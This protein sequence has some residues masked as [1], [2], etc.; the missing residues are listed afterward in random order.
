MWCVLWSDFHQQTDRP[1]KHERKEPI[2]WSVWKSCVMPAVVTVIE[3][4]QDHDRKDKRGKVSELPNTR[5]RQ[6]SRKSTRA[7]ERERTSNRTHNCDYDRNRNRNRNCKP[8]H[9]V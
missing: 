2:L 5:A 6:D 7:H 3:T 1:I 4:N 8:I 9:G